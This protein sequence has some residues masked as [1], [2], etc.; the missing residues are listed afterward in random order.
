[1]GSVAVW[2]LNGVLQPFVF[3]IVP[4]SVAVL[5][6]VALSVLA[7]AAAAALAPAARAMRVRPLQGVLIG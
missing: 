1:L 4:R 3:G 5:L 2:Q 6:A 7:L